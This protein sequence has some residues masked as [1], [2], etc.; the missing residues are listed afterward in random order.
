VQ[1]KRAKK[2]IKAHTKEKKK[3]QLVK[4]AEKKQLTIRLRQAEEHETDLIDRIR[5]AKNQQADL[6]RVDLHD[7][8]IKLKMD[9][10]LY[11][12]IIF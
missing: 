9:C 6:M 1:Q 2:V 12:H 4:P 7:A 3:S 10:R 8:V 5:E 11:E